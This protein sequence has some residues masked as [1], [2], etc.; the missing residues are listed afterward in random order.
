MVEQQY[1]NNYSSALV[2][3]NIDKRLPHDIGYIIFRIILWIK[4]GYFAGW[5]DRK[6]NWLSQKRAS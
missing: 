5:V 4:F 1:A 3:E 6:P 2:P